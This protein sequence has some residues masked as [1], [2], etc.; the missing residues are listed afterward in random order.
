MGDEIK[1]PK[2]Q[3]QNYV[4][5][6]I[7]KIADDVYNVRVSRRMFVDEH[8]PHKQFFRRKN[9]IKG[10]NQARR[11]KR[12]LMDE[13]AQEAMKNKGGDVKWSAVRE[14]Y[15]ACLEERHR[16][17]TLEASTMRNAIQTFDKY[18]RAWDT[19]WLSEIT[20]PFLN[21]FIT[22]DKLKS[23]TE[24]AT[25]QSLLKFIR[26]ALKIQIIKGRLKYDPTAGLII[27]VK[28]KESYPVS[29]THNDIVLLIKYARGL[30][31]EWSDAWADV[32][33]VAYLCGARSGE[34]WSLTWSN[35]IL[36]GSDKKIKI[37]YSYDWKTEKTKPTKG[38]KD[39]MIPL[40]PT[41][42]KSL[43]RLKEKYPNSE[44][45]L[46]RIPDWKRG[47]GAEI[48][49][50][51]LDGLKVDVELE[52][53]GEDL[54]KINFHSLRGSF[55]TNLLL[56]NEPLIKV[57]ALA[58]HEDLATTRR[59]LRAIGSELKGSTD[60]LTLDLEDANGNLIEAD[61]NQKKRQA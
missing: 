19:K 38:K 50:S 12:E 6:G 17:S 18:T 36:E 61:F 35:V 24:P 60:A 34:L 22:N 28:K 16:E 43:R 51:Y 14:D 47:E 4:E 23:E 41:L 52:T 49:R 13:L 15:H 58:G 9:N 39:R 21:A 26:G 55:I 30:N 2:E 40:S 32:Y 8:Q 56:K 53:K 33:E 37:K 44:Y 31:Q 1:K 59:Y 20:S 46:P 57:M 48:I 3:K 42:E 29:L 11:V 54:E 7:I 45:V 25:R 27:R 5:A 10:L